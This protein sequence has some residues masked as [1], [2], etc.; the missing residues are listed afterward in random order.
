MKENKNKVLYNVKLIVFLII[1]LAIARIAMIICGNGKINKL[2]GYLY[3]LAASATCSD[4]TSTDATSADATSSNATSSN[5]NH[6]ATSS[7]ATSADANK[8]D[9]TSADATSSNATGSKVDNQKSTSTE[10]NKEDS[11]TKKNNTSVK[12]EI[13]ENNKIEE[14]NESTASNTLQENN[15]VEQENVQ[16][17]EETTVIDNKQISATDKTSKENKKVV[18]FLESHKTYI[19]I[20]GMCVLAIV[21]V[22]VIIAIDKKGIQKRKMM[23]E[24]QEESMPKALRKDDEDKN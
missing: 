7:N 14:A 17:E 16:K 9:A 5:A 18:S 3:S 21:I 20:I 1:I 23:K 15:N 12:N 8:Q 4:A 2:E 11:I 10:A 6:D 22:S 13:N 19:I 24:N